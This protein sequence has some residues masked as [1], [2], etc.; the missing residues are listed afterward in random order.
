MGLALHA[1]APG[2]VADR[3]GADHDRDPHEHRRLAAAAFVRLAREAR[4][5][6]ELVFLQVMT[7]DSLHDSN[8]QPVAQGAPQRGGVTVNC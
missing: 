8:R 4:E 5:I 3:D 6:L 1:L 2:D 7:F